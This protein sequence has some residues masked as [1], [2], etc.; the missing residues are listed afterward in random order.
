MTKVAHLLEGIL[1]LFFLFQMYH[2]LMVVVFLPGFNFIHNVVDQ[3]ISYVQMHV[4]DTV[5]FG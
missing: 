4:A 3:L 2:R 1:K 5:R